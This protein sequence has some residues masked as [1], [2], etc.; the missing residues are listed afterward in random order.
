[1]RS[2]LRITLSV[3][4]LA[5]VAVPAT[6]LEPVHP[7][8][9]LWRTPG[10]GSTFANFAINPLP[11]G[12]FCDGSA[13]FAGTVVFEG[14]PVATDPAEVLGPTDT[15][16]HRLDQAVF[17]EFGV[18]KT[19][20][21]MRAMQFKGT[22]LL[23]NSCGT[24]RVGLE[25]DGEQPITTMKIVQD[26]PGLGRFLAPIHVNVRMTFTPVDHGGDTK[27]VQRQLRF[28]PAANAVWS[29]APGD[30]FVEFGQELKVDSDGDGTPDRFVPGTSSN[31]FVGST[32]GLV[33]DGGILRR[34]EMQAEAGP[35]TGS[36]KEPGRAVTPQAD[37]GLSQTAGALREESTLS[38]IHI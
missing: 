26:R 24:F 33:R 16:I 12:F 7:G 36:L 15:I 2:I 13:P 5:L 32:A 23:R 14:V 27:F 35:E 20:I 19:R 17:N 21:Q 4:L 1:M 11:A 34:G 18:A 6:A 38:L 22:E 25:L 8:S 3:A 9:D 30:G 28:S 10:D 37:G 31:F 29:S